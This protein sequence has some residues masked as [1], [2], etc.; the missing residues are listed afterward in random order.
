M[1]LH[2]AHIRLRLARRRMQQKGTGMKKLAIAICT[3]A[4]ALCALTACGGG[5]ESPYAGTWKLDG[6][7]MEGLEMTLEDLEMSADDAVI[8]I[9]SDGTAEMTM[10]GDTYS[11]TWTEADG[12]LSL[13]DG[14]DTLNATI[15]DDGRLSIDIE[16]LAMLFA[17][18]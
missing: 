2:R 4:V 18:A 15:L 6:F 7:A 10:D 5:A 13:T 14:T 11:L 17:K 12:T 9:N 8:V 16:G 1:A 3:L